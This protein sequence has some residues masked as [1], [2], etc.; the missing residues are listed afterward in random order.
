MANRNSEADQNDPIRQF[1]QENAEMVASY[2]SDAR[3]TDASNA[4]RDLAFEK[5]YMYNFG[6][7]DRPIIQFPSDMV[8]FQEIVWR[9]KPDLIIETGIAHGG[10]L[11]LSASMLAMLDLEESIAAQ[12]PYDPKQSKRRVLG[13]DIDIRAHN[14]QQIESHPFAY[15]IDMF[16]GSSIDPAMIER[17][18]DYAAGFKTVLVSLDSNHTA[19]HVLAELKGYGPIVTEGSYCLVFDT[20]VED[21]P[22]DLFPNRPWSQSNNPKGAVR[23]FLGLCAAGDITDLQGAECAF[24]IDHE[25]EAKLMVSSAPSGYLRRS[26][27]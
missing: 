22:D 18:R 25:L 12:K 24:E 27:R 10:S 5:R 3:W 26:P 23:D 14:R 13:I 1:K 17:T 19:D 9:I 20:V 15:L 4:W 16:E 6:W 21:L 11:I 2:G 7:L 8:A